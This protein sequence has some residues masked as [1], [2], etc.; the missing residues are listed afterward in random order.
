MAQ[1]PIDWSVFDA[2]PENTCYCRCGT[3]FRSHAKF[4]TD[5][6]DGKFGIVSRIAC[7]ACK[8]DNRL[9]QVSSDP[10]YMTIR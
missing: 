4:V 2:F 9:R 1:A 5:A 10:E 7:P 8:L 3:V 6:G